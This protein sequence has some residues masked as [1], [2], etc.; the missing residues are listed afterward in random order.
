MSC[1][2]PGQLVLSAPLSR[3]CALQARSTR[4]LGS[5]S[6]FH[7][8]LG[9]SSA[10]LVLPRVIAALLAFFAER[11]PAP[12]CL[13]LLVQRQMQ[14]TIPAHQIAFLWVLA[15]TH[16]RAVP[17]Q[18]CVL[19]QASTVRERLMIESM[20]R[21]ARNQLLHQSVKPL[22]RRRGGSTSPSR[23]TSQP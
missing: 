3:R 12:R 6:V 9:P 23:G 17:C 2:R 14:G 10:A 4:C 13:A 16:Q 19:L 11:A 5:Q 18:S 21:L 8:L 15:S 7:A 20:T 1:V 22:L